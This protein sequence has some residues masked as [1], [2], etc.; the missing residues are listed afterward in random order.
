M[1]KTLTGIAT[2]ALGLALV[3][4]VAATAV[5]DVNTRKLRSAVTVNGILQHERALQRIANQNGGTRASGTPGYQASVDYVAG[6][7]RRAGYSVRLQ[8]FTFPFFRVQA[9]AQLS[10]VSPTATEYETSTFTFSGSGAVTGQLVPTRD[11]VIPPAATPSSTSGCEPGDFPTAPAT[12]A[13]AL[14]QRGTC[15]FGVKARN[16]AAAGYDAVIIFNEGQPGRTELLTSVTL[17]APASIPVVG[18]DFAS[19]AALYAAAQAGTVTV[20]V[21]TSTEA[22]L[23]AKTYNVIADTPKGKNGDET[24]VVGAH[25]DSVVEGPGINDNGSGSAGILEIA[26]QMAALKYNNRLQ[27]RVR[28]AFWGAEESGLLGS[29]HYVNNLTDTQREQLYANLNFDMIGSPN[30]VRFVYDGDGSDTAV[31]GPVG[32]EAIERIFTD[33]FTSVGL[34]SEPTEFSGRSD[35]GPFIEVGIPAGGLFSGAEGIKTAAQAATYGGTAGVAYDKCYHQACDTMA[36][37]S[38]RALFELGDA[39]AHA[40]YTLA[41]SKRG[42][43]PDGARLQSKAARKAVKPDQSGHALAR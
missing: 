39:A 32:S 31:A 25:L 4:P 14:I 35:Y 34:A 30:Y 3:S 17:A 12:P 41:K 37:L 22:D 27:R 1:R 29:T 24:V 42:L 10:Q 5:D 2:L 20:R 15:E 9:P 38:S 11:I 23:N 26:E 7:L 40:V 43:Y 28:F 19:G 33:Y 18:L 16:A 13:V 8:E 21:S 36:N 6:K